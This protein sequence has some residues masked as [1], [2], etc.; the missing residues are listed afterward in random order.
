M[1]PLRNRGWRTSFRNFE[2]LKTVTVVW[3]L[4]IQRVQLLLVGQP[5][6]GLPVYILRLSPIKETSFR[7]YSMIISS[8]WQ[9][10]Q[11]PVCF[12]NSVRLKLMLRPTQTCCSSGF[13]SVLRFVNR[14]RDRIT[15]SFKHSDGCWGGSDDYCS[16]TKSN[17]SSTQTDFVRREKLMDSEC[18]QFLIDDVSE[19]CNVLEN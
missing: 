4:M 19:S 13:S 17:Q 18:E 1:G 6:T 12:W 8:T 16:V 14:N 3:T 7:S 2:F 9:K 11:N 10:R 5:V 15:R